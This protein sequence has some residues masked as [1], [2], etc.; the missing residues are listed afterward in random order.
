MYSEISKIDVCLDSFFK[1]IYNSLVILRHISVFGLLS[2][3]LLGNSFYI[4]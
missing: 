4:C 1:Q 2:G 3:H